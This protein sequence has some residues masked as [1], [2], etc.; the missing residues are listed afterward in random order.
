MWLLMGVEQPAL[1][2]V[3]ARLP[4][5]TLSLAAFEV[6]FGIA[7]VIES[8]IL[9]I[10]SAAT[11]LVRG[12]RTYRQMF[13]FMTILAV[14]LTALHFFLG[15][16]GVFPVIA[17]GIL[18]VPSHVIEPARKAFVW[19]IP[20]AALVGYR[21]LWQGSL[22][23]MGNTGVVAHTMV[24]RLVT[25]MLGLTLGVVLNRSG[26]ASVPGSIVAGWS[27]IGGVFA[28]AAASWWFYRRA[29]EGT[30]HDPSAIVSEDDTPRSGSALL[31]FYVPLSLTSVMAL[32]SRPILA[33]GI[34]RSV[35][36]LESLATWPVINGL[37]FMFT[38]IA[39]SYQ[40]AVVA[41]AKECIE[42]VAVLRRFG[43]LLTAT[44]TAIFLAISVTGGTEVWFRGVAGLRPELVELARKAMIFLIVMP[45]AVTG[46]S[47]FSG[48]LVAEEKTIFL[49][50]AVLANTVVLLSAVI[51]LP[52]LT[53][54]VG[55]VVAAIAFGGAN[56]VQL[57]VLW[58]GHHTTARKM[59]RVG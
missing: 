54:L 18:G 45:I 28:G 32:V 16:P 8:P 44:L 30:T 14:T 24:I 4:Q 3:M 31:K 33:F 43:V 56:V 40:E 39:L 47:Y 46:R 59:A 7:L 12:P 55:T 15:R 52:R 9:Q 29:R 34:S 53:D 1:N 19:L 6:A 37:L 13:R 51:F 58:Y 27:L 22:I 26:A 35:L 25:T 21:R 50:V 20:F 17:G 42:N 57:A 48:L 11:A 5:A 2:G 10:L 41:K 38:S 36:P 49:T 23:Q